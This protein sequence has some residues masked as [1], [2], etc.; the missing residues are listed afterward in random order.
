MPA[1]LDPYQ[2]MQ[3]NLVNEQKKVAAKWEEEYKQKEDDD[4]YEFV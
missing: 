2:L 4:S 1:G 3:I